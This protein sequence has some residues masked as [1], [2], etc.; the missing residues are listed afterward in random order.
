MTVQL[1]VSANGLWA[2]SLGIGLVAAL[3]V[4]FLLIVLVRAVDDIDRSV[5][6][7]LEVA[8]KV[9]GN[10][11]NIPQLE[12]TAPVLGLIVEEAVVQDRYMNALTDGYGD[13]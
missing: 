10:T 7:L 11:A 3:V 9:A 6:G 8:G 4:A 1:A 5:G 12:A 13:S 2:V